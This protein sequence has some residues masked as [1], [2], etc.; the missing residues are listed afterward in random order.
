MFTWML[1][2]V[3][4]KVKFLGFL[5]NQC[6]AVLED[7]NLYLVR[8]IF[9]F[10][11]FCLFSEIQ[12]RHRKVVEQGNLYVEEQMGILDNMPPPR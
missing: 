9:G 1:L 5:V 6:E 7:F 8:E 3:W 4:Q 2:K 12:I 11:L 10:I